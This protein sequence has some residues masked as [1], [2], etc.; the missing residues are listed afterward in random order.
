MGLPHA[1][2]GVAQVSPRARVAH[3]RA[4]PTRVAGMVE[5]AVLFVAVTSL[6]LPRAHAEEGLTRP[7]LDALEAQLEAAEHAYA[8]LDVVVFT[9][10]LD[11]AALLLPCVNQP[12][13]PAVAAHFHRM[14]GL[15]LFGAGDEDAALDALRAARVLDPRYRFPEDVLPSDHA[16]RKQYDALGVADTSTWRPPRP[17]HGTLAFDGLPS[18]LRA[19]DRATVFQELDESGLPATTEYLYPG[20]PTPHYAAVPRT[21]NRLL[22]GSVGAALIAGTFYT[23]AWT[24]RAAFDDPDNTGMTLDGLES[25]RTQT[26]VF[27]GLSVGFLVVGVAGGTSALLVHERWDP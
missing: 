9:N 17:T 5:G 3:S 24:S 4:A 6:W 25:L 18:R 26:Q 15:R 20:Q 14:E 19:T 8:A 10:S 27:S 1:P 7:P 16:L 22:A 12:M 11:E 13:T 23:L 2:N 21:R